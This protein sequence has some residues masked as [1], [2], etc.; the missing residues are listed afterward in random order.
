[1][2]RI[3]LAGTR[4]EAE[5]VTRAL[6]QTF[7]IP[8]EILDPATGLKLKKIDR[9][10]AAAAIAAFGLAYGALDSA[11]LPFDFL[12]PKR[13]QAPG[14]DKRTQYLLYAAA[15]SVAFF[16]LV[17]LRTVMI[18]QRTQTKTELQAQVNLAQAEVNHV[19]GNYDRIKGWGGTAESEAA[20]ALNIAQAHLTVAQAEL[21]R[22]QLSFTRV[23]APVTGT[24][25]RVDVRKGET[26]FPGS[27]LLTLADLSVM[28]VKVFIP[29]PMLGKI[30]FGQ[31]VKIVS[32]SFP[33]QPLQG[34]VAYISPEAEFTP[35]NIQTR[36]ERTRLVYQVKVRVP[37]PDGILK[38]GMP[39]DA[40][41]V[42]E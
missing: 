19:Q 34:V 14:Q 13:P 12:N 10:Q 2:E 22:T 9:A 33:Q 35:K 39:L 28:D 15:A 31:Q 41:F 18:R 25:L 6:T 7:R 32:D 23:M 36:E 21:A 8:C 17:G 38:I 4:P 5:A 24:V 16:G 26:A 20:H 37:N 29:E 42:K 27:A 3:Y 1:V 40:I 30:K 11:G